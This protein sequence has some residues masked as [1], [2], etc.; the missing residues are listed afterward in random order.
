MNKILILICILTICSA[1]KYTYSFD[2]N[3]INYYGTWV[4]WTPHSE[5]ASLIL[6]KALW[7]LKQSAPSFVSI[8]GAIPKSNEEIKKAFCVARIFKP[9]RQIGSIILTEM[10]NQFIELSQEHNM[11]ICDYKLKTIDTTAN[12]MQILLTHK[13]SIILDLSSIKIS[14]WGGYLY[15]PRGI[16]FKGDIAEKLY[17]A[18]A[19][20]YNN[21]SPSENF[22]TYKEETLQTPY[23]HDDYLD[24]RLYTKIQY[25]Y[26]E[27]LI[28]IME[29]VKY[30]Y[31]PIKTT[32]P[33]TPKWTMCILMHDN[34][35]PNTAP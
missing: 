22:F 13:G 14:R 8:K 24:Y 7:E 19:K 20:I 26:Q 1:F 5:K 31:Y 28:E 9:T 11:I 6:T 4:N 15:P 10:K 35:Q 32:R 25:Q 33:A 34:E 27:K 2:N 21:L 12:N 23:E 3:E 16:A 29:C 18:F 30:Y 17:D